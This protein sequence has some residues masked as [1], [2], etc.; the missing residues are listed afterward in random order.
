LP[1]KLIATRAANCK[2]LA[3]VGGDAHM[4]PDLA[5]PRS[6]AG[7]AFSALRIEPEGIVWLRT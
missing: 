6:E 4:V 7:D 3:L 5:Y 1:G 2:R